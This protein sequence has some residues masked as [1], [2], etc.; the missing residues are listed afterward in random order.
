MHTDVKIV[1]KGQTNP[2]AVQTRVQIIK[3]DP[4]GSARRQPS[5]PRLASP[6]RV[7][8]SSSALDALPKPAGVRRVADPL[9]R[10][11]VPADPAAQLQAAITRQQEKK[12]E[13]ER[14]IARFEKALADL[15]G[16]TAETS[17]ND[18]LVEDAPSPESVAASGVEIIDVPTNVQIVVEPDS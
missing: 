15:Q 17:S 16:R 3:R 13:A 9:P 1:P 8:T 4:T 5:A 18:E 12:A 10:T 2:L 7:V 6:T 14:N 11:D